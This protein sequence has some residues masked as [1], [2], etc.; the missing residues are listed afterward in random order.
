MS[1]DVLVLPSYRE[2]FGSVIIEASFCGI[3][4]I[5]SRI[6]GISDAIVD[7]VT[8]IL[9]E[10]GNVTQIVGAMRCMCNGEFRNQL[11]K[12]ALRRA[13][14]L[15]CRERIVSLWMDIYRNLQASVPK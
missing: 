8:G 1:S 10:P 4:T 13:H 6:Y 11:A 14:S 3:P 7:R 15:Y 9:H 5:A 12:N 2:G